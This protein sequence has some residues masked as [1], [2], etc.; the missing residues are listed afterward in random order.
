[1]AFASRALLVADLVLL[2]TM[3]PRAPPQIFQLRI[4]TN[5]LTVFL[6]LPSATRIPSVKTDVLSALNAHVSQGLATQEVTSVDDFVLAREVKERGRVVP[7][8]YEMLEEDRALKEVVSNWDAIFIQFKDASGKLLPV[9]VTIP[10]LDD[11]D[12]PFESKSTLPSDDV[13]M[14]YL[15]PSGKGKRKAPPE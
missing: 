7:G 5:K 15:D 8:R 1:M 4:K 13:S 6:S 2:H 9:E 11:P 3:R 12:E 10:S 14:E